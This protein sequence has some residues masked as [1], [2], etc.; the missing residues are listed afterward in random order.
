M[1]SWKTEDTLDRVRIDSEHGSPA[2]S[3]GHVSD[4][5]L[6]FETARDLGTRV[7]RTRHLYFDVQELSFEVEFYMSR[8]L[9]SDWELV[10]R[11]RYGRQTR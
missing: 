10:Q 2:L 8:S 6:V 3:I 4:D 1:F 7:L 11:S 5:T 9:D